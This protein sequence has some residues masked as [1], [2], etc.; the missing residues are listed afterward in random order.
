MQSFI[1]KGPAHHALYGRWRMRRWLSTLLP[2][3]SMS[4]RAFLGTFNLGRPDLSTVAQSLAGGRTDSALRHLAEHFRARATPHLF[5]TAGGQLGSAALADPRQKATTIHLADE[6]CDNQFHFRGRTVRFEGAVDWRH[7]PDG[8]PDWTWD[9]NRHAYFEQLGRAYAYTADERYARKYRELL[10]DWLVHN[11]PGVRQPNWASV[12]EVA[13]R[14][15]VWLWTYDYFRASFYADELWL[16]SLLEGLWAHGYFLETHLEYHVPNN[17]LL[18]EAKAL[19]MLGV[20]F[21]EFR[22]ATRWKKRGLS[23]AFQQIRSQIEPDGVHSERAAH[24]HRV[25]AGELLELLVLLDNNDVPVPDDVRL[26]FER[27][28]AFELWITKPDGSLPLLGDS[29]LEDT[30][31]RFLATRGGPAFLFRPDLKGVAPEPAEAEL[32]LLGPGRIRRW[33]DASPITPTALG[34]RSFVTGGYYIMRHGNGPAAAH[35]VFD[36]APFGDRRVPGH[37]HADALSLELYADHQ[38]WLVDP[39]VYSTHAAPAWRNFFRGTRAHNTVVVDGQDQS[40]LV[41]TRGVYRPARVTLHRWW[42]SAD[43]DW[44]DASHHGYERLAH[45]ITHRRHIVFIKPDCWV[46]FDVLSG[47][48]RHCFE[49]LYH[50]LPE[51]QIDLGLGA[52]RVS[53]EGDRTLCLA[54][55]APSGTKAEVV[56]GATNP[57]QGWVA[58]HSGTKQAAPTLQLRHD[59]EAPVTFCTVIRLAAAGA[60]APVC[61]SPFPIQRATS[62]NLADSCQLS[63]IMIDAETNR[64][65]LIVDHELC[66]GEESFAGYPHAGA[67]LYVRQ[68]CRTHEVLRCVSA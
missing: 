55:L 12:F 13:F 48:G 14:I 42:S 52:A 17:H 11:P 34:S 3:R 56:V 43:I 63:S 19:A 16:R 32:W 62:P 67:L 66:Q 9:L 53:G 37:G 51:H 31:W 8:N 61:V 10:L 68:D 46:V 49:L 50:F 35:L 41:G 39:G 27:M 29:S 40:L 24:Y 58:L 5:V 26:A 2:P 22:Q 15:N 65:Y 20:A 7:S 44:V 54:W 47:T 21:P 33:A 64:D 28:L 23:L 60:T 4:D 57:I 38:T 6:I 1:A 18:L 36:A 59:G 45:P 30:H 25:V